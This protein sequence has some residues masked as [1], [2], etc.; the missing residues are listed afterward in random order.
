MTFAN[1]VCGSPS[2]NN[3][4][5][6]AESVDPT[7]RRDDSRGKHRARG[8]ISRDHLHLSRY[9]SLD[10]ARVAFW[11]GIEPLA[12]YFGRIDTTADA[13]I[14]DIV[15]TTHSTGILNR[16]LQR[17]IDAVAEALEGLRA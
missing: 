17:G 1:V 4:R 15:D 16:K 11:D 2:A 5:A 7:K 14:D 6:I 10:R 13:A 3:R 8:H 12:G 9:V